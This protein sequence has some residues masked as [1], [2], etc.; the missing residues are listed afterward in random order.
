MKPVE[1]LPFDPAKDGEAMGLRTERPETMH[2][3][4]HLANII[5]LDPDVLFDVGKRREG[6]GYYARLLSGADKAR[7]WVFV[8]PDEIVAALMAK[9]EVVNDGKEPPK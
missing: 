1:W 6:G 9:V 7:G 5:G 8:L 3:R 4:V 2:M